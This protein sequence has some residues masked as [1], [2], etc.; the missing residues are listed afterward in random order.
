MK[1]KTFLIIFFSSLVLFAG[2][3]TTLGF[4]LEIV[5]KDIGESQK[6]MH[7]SFELA[8]ELVFSSQWLTRFSRGYV[9]IKDPTRLAYYDAV[10]GILDGK[11]ETPA[12]YD[13][14]YWDLVAGGFIPFNLN[15]SKAG[16]SIEDRFLK[17]NITTEEYSKLK[18]AR[19]QIA[20]SCVM[21]KI[22][23]HAV[24]GE[25]DDGTGTFTRKGKPDRGM[26]ERLIYGEE[27]NKI[28]GD[29]SL[30]IKEFNDF[31]KKRFSTEISKKEDR[32]NSLLF[33]NLST[34]VA[35]S[36]MILAALLFLTFR[37][38]KRA[39]YL[40][41][42]VEKISAGDLSVRTHISG[43]DELSQLSNSIDIMAD[44]LRS[45]FI[46]L[47]E[48]IDL[49]QKALIE[50]DNERNRSEKLLHN[51]LPAAIA[52]RLREGEE[53][54]AE[55]FPEVTVA[56]SDI[57]GFTE[58][59]ANLGPH[60]TVQMLSEIFGELDEL[61]EKHSVEKIKTIGDCYMVV[62]G[63]PNR[64]NLHCQHI[65]NFALDAMKAVENFSRNFPV[66]VRMR[67]G[68]HTGTVAAGVVGK[69]K[70][71]YDLWG[72][73]VNIASRFETT[74]S[75]D[76]IHVSEAIKV[77]LADDFVFFAGGEIDLKGKGMTRSYYLLGRKEHLPQLETLA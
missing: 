20:K 33:I 60:K 52:D 51:I 1:I 69:K 68:I 49:S 43:E 17:L 59:S 3:N 76:R 26:A 36:G 27:Y 64:D 50:L 73:V 54:I 6:K 24:N 10:E 12:T 45:A 38:A 4:I 74:S 61:A 48:K 18:D 53:T 14:G 7:E 72:D 30:L 57:V 71:S 35:L 47:E 56:F 29:I 15:T 70:F 58:L 21:E 13:L 11:I 46:K 16:K 25:Y 19:I 66:N 39:T 63:V 42:S 2:V 9:A 77:R 40:L 5:E 65:A 32:A 23:M 41:N 37:L 8:Q 28:N 44:N 62:G 31:V 75:P 55:I 67:M 22:A 34:A